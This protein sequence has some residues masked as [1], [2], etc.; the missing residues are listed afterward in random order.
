MRFASCHYVAL[1]CQIP[2]PDQQA[3]MEAQH[4]SAYERAAVRLRTRSHVQLR[5]RHPQSRPGP[6]T[7]GPFALSLDSGLGYPGRTM[8]LD[9]RRGPLQDC[10]PKL[11]A[12]LRP[13][14]DDA[15]ECAATRES[16]EYRDTFGSRAPMWT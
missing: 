13:D 3:Q 8:S 6:A 4:G 11:R 14:A 10:H 16:L 2:F 1:P 7:P 5:L 12:G 9:A 15:H